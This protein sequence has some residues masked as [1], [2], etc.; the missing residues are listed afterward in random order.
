MLA[1][2]LWHTV[3]GVTFGVMYALIFGQGSWLWALAWGTAVWLAMMIAMPLM[4]PTLALPN[5]FP[6][7]PFVAHVAM[8]GPFVLLTLWV[9]DGADLGSLVGWLAA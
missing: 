7:V 1:G 5:W 4:M 9:S 6:V 8:V 3:N 2:Y